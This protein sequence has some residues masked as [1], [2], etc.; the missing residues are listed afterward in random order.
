MSMYNF[1]TMNAI[2]LKFRVVWSPDFTTVT[3]IWGAHHSPLKNK[4]PRLPMCVCVCEVFQ[5]RYQDQLVGG[6]NPFKKK[7][8]LWIQVGAWNA[9]RVQFSQ[10]VL[11]SIGTSQNGNL[12]QNTL[13]PPANDHIISH[14]TGSSEKHRRPKVTA[15]MRYV[16]NSR[17]VVTYI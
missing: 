15:G 11:G 16:R 12:P 6:F 17:R 2:F 4:H 10:E 9:L 14:Q 13:D 8:S 3:A 7:Y 1:R 5:P